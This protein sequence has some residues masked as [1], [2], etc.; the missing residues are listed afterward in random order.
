[1]WDIQLDL[2]NL[3]IWIPCQGVTPG[4]AAS[5]H[6]APFAK[7]RNTGRELAVTW[8]PDSL[9]TSDPSKNRDKCLAMSLYNLQSS[10]RSILFY[11]CLEIISEFYN[12]LPPFSAH[13]THWWSHW[14]R[15]HFPN[16]PLEECGLTGL[17]PRLP[18]QD[19]PDP[20]FIPRIRPP[21]IFNSFHGNQK[22]IWQRWK[23]F[24]VDT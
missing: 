1:M 7:L 2:D 22:N 9:D 16:F 21:I 14:P 8:W 24:Y 4:Q 20:H 23:P 13:S 12:L 18:G 15:P 6:A 3:S 19:I 11:F 17:S 5:L 10:I